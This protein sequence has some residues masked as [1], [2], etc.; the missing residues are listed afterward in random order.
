MAIWVGQDGTLNDDD[1]DGAAAALPVDINVT[2]QPQQSVP[3]AGPDTVQQPQVDDQGNQMLDDQQP[4]MPPPDPQQQQQQQQPPPRHRKRHR[5]HHKH[6]KHHGKGKGG[7]TPPGT[8]SPAPP[9]SS[10]VFPTL[11]SGE[12]VGT[13]SM[14]PFTDWDGLLFEKGPGQY[15]VFEIGQPVF[16]ADE[17]ADIYPPLDVEEYEEREA[18]AQDEAN[19]FA[20]TPLDLLS[21]EQIARLPI[22]LTTTFTGYEMPFTDWDGNLLTASHPFHFDYPRP[23]TFGPP[24]RTGWGEP[25]T[26]LGGHLLEGAGQYGTFI[27][28]DPFDHREW[29][30]IDR[31]RLDPEGNQM[32]H[33]LVGQDDL[34]SSLGSALGSAFG[35]SGGGD[36]GGGSGGLGSLG[37]LLGGDSGGGGGGL[38]GLLGGDSSGGG[39][40]VGSIFGSLASAAAKAAIPALA[41]A[42]TQALSQ[43][44]SKPHGTP[45]QQPTTT[46]QPAHPATQH[47]ANVR[48]HVA[49]A[50][51]HA[52]ANLLR[53]LSQL[54]DKYGIAKP[55]HAPH[56]Q[57]TSGEWWG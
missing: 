35:G 41:K 8:P 6:H 26:D 9:P 43:E 31:A 10:M 54:A 13:S 12:F 51:R 47:A 29:S 7:A 55:I 22:P 50:D 20:S 15:Q 52:R 4:D 2:V 1:G 16:P 34:G 32:Y 5:R 33:F 30:D 18:S 36:A 21:D 38:G 40:D 53:Q 11:T 14:Y 28:S 17:P 19:E 42:G 3:Q 27:V 45:S 48:H 39:G 49:K 56:T 23:E 25:F 37:G 46:Q 24:V 44:L 57:A